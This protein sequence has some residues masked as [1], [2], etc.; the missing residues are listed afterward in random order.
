[1]EDYKFW[2]TFVFGLCGFAALILSLR[3]S[4][5]IRRVE[6]EITN[7]IDVDA[8]WSRPDTQGYTTCRVSAMLYPVTEVRIKV[9]SDEWFIEHLEPNVSQQRQFRTVNSGVRYQIQFRDPATGSKYTKKRILR[10]S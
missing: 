10:F 8:K 3:D 6:D 4:Y 9:P 5:R 1:M 2:I 7:E